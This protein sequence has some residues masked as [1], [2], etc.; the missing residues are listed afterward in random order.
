M[1]NFLNFSVSIF[2]ILLNN[3]FKTKAQCEFNSGPITYSAIADS[4]NGCTLSPRGTIRILVIL[5]EV[6]YTAPIPGDPTPPTG[7]THW[8]SGS[9]PDWADN[10]TT[11]V[12]KAFDINIPTGSANGIITKYFQQASFGQLNVIADY[13]IP[14]SG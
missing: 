9:L 13:L 5:C 2:I 11:G 7:N 3:T 6:N 8:H 1:R 12:D 4:R 10:T 14:N